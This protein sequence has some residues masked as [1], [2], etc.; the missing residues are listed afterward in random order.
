LKYKGRGCKKIFWVKKTGEKPKRFRLRVSLF[1]S[2][3]QHLTPQ[4]NIKPENIVIIVT[5]KFIKNGQ[6]FFSTGKRDYFSQS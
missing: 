2:T 4:Q 3:Y 6:Q 1:F 5:A